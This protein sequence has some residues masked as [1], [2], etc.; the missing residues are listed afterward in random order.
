M[1]FFSSLNLNPLALERPKTFLEYKLLRESKLSKSDTR[2]AL[3]LESLYLKHVLD[4][5][6]AT[7]HKDS[8]I[9]QNIYLQNY[10]E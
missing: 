2:R 10:L 6:V 4:F 7:G 3:I 5:S 8:S 1:L 9:W